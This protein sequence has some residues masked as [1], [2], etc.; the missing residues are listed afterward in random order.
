M[1]LMA[2]HR[3]LDPAPWVAARPWVA[4]AAR[5]A[6]WMGLLAIAWGV[7]LQDPMRRW[8]D[9]RDRIGEMDG[10][11]AEVAPVQ[12]ESPPVPFDSSASPA[13]P[14]HA[15]AARDLLQVLAAQARAQGL[16]VDRFEMGAPRT[17]SAH[18][19]REP[20]R[21]E[22]M[23]RGDSADRPG[24]A[25]RADWAARGSFASHLAFMA[26][27]A[28]RPVIAWRHLRLEA[29][30]GGPVGMV[31]L[32]AQLAPLSPS[33]GNDEVEVGREMSLPVPVVPAPFSI[34]RDLATDK[35]AGDD[36]PPAAPPTDPLQR[37]LAEMRLVATVLGAGQARA[38]LRIGSH[39]AVIRSGDRLGR[40]AAVLQTVQADRIA[41]ELPTRDLRWVAVTADLGP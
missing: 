28:H 8:L 26:A 17:V 12:P 1:W 2:G 9:Q 16:S 4:R 34:E 23:Q 30:A 21:G 36:G 11:Q 6:L 32:T 18:A 24:K 13:D 20:D 38:V 15:W 5:A 25:D 19:P 41:L 14:S 7:V 35:R 10:P 29:E 33:A 3:W 37:D 31:T 27:L 39:L 22:E 40:P